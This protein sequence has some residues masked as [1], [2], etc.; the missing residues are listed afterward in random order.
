MLRKR[1][2]NAWVAR[3]CPRA[4]RVGVTHN[5]R[6]SI[7]PGHRPGCLECA[8]H[9]LVVRLKC[10]AAVLEALILAALGGPARLGTCVTSVLHPMGLTED[11]QIF[12]GFRATQAH[13]VLQ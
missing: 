8:L 1:R 6:P 3:S 11:I 9:L 10:P 13:K 2:A 7:G 12:N 5:D 4:P